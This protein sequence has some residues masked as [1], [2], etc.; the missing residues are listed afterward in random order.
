MIIKREDGRFYNQIRSVYLQYDVFSYADASVLFEIGKT[1]V[2]TSVTL[3]STVPHFLKG[4]KSGWLTAEYSMLPCSTHKRTIREVNQNRR[5]FRGIEISRLIGRCLRCVVDLSLIP[6]KSII[7]DCDVLQADGGTR[8]ASI[9]AASLALELAV[10]RWMEKG[11]IKENILKEHIV[12]ISVGVLNDKHILDLSYVE[13][14]QADSD[15]NFIF[16][17]S[18]RLIEIQGTAEKNSLPWKEFEKLKN[19]ALDGIKQL[20]LECRKFSVNVNL[21]KKEK[22]KEDRICRISKKSPLFSI[23]NRT[24]KEI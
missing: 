5:N 23:G 22:K 16:T 9:T 3:Q 24:E 2:L 6:D 11:I 7:I 13:D 17:A 12:A 14:S 10:K 18:E 8:V 21:E 15:F 20:F 4:Q 1:K 19:I